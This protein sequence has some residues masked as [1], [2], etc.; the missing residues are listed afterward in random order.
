MRKSETCCNGNEPFARGN[1]VTTQFVLCR[2]IFIASSATGWSASNS[3]VSQKVEGAQANSS[4]S[5]MKQSVYPA[6]FGLLSV[7]LLTSD[8]SV[9]PGQDCVQQPSLLEAALNA[10]ADSRAMHACKC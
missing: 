5:T 3:R 4:V 2:R 1:R 7:D 8:H 6:A 10:R 9:I